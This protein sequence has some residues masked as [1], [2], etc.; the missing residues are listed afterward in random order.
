MLII[1]TK[2]RIVGLASLLVSDICLPTFANITLMEK[3][4]EK[5]YYLANITRL[6]IQAPDI[7]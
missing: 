5:D 2:Y 7:C 3:L 4:V 1:S 6:D